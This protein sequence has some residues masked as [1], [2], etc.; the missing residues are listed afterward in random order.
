MAYEG[1]TVGVN[2]ADIQKDYFTV[3]TFYTIYHYD[4]NHHTNY[5]TNMLLTCY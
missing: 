4:P 1:N 2:T 5:H 3:S